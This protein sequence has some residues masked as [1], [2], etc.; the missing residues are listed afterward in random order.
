MTEKKNMKSLNKYDYIIVGAGLAGCVAA[1]ELTDRG[2]KCLVID[3]RDHLGGN[4]YSYKVGKID[5]HKYGP[6]IFHTCKRPLWEYINKFSEWKPYYHKVKSQHKGTM[7]DFPPNINTITQLCGVDCKFSVTPEIENKIYETFYAGYTKKAWDN[8]DPPFD[9]KKRIPIKLTT[10]NHYW[11]DNYQG[12]PVDGYG[13]WFE[14]IMSGI[15]VVLGVDFASFETQTVE[16]PKIFSGRIDRA[17]DYDFGKL[18]YK[19]VKFQTEIINCEFTQGVPSVNYADSDI[20]ML[21]EMEWKFF[22]NSYQF[23][24]DYT[25]ITKEYFDKN[26]EDYPIVTETTSDLYQKYV[27]EAGN[28]GITLIGRSGL[29][30]YMS[31]DATIESTLKIVESLNC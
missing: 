2:A 14:A 25:V 31:M 5:V 1:R 18:A 28:A 29:Y 15:D 21:R 9:V 11:Y 12:L 23:E 3:R 22:T 16:I 30:K 13:H 7:Y 4:C 10:D 24:C 6:H 26:G 19:G 8:E 27:Y 20:P 17:F